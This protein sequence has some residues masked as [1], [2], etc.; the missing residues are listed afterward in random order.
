[1]KRIKGYKEMNYNI[2]DVFVS[3]GKLHFDM[4]QAQRYIS[5]LKE[6]LDQKDQQIADLQKSINDQEQDE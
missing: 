1:M 2:D 3:L 5:L 6:E 4:S